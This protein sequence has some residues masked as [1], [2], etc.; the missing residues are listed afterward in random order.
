MSKTA[1]RFETNRNSGKSTL[2]GYFPIGY[3]TLEESIT[4]AIAMCKNGVDVLELGVP[5]SDPVMDGLVIQ[6]ATEQALANGFKLKQTFEAVARVTAEVDTPVL[7]MTYWNPVMQYGV[8]KFASELKTA[9]GAGLITPDLI[10]DE[11]SDWL[12]ISDRLDL[13]RVF[14]ATPTSSDSRMQRA[15]ELSRGFVYSVSTMG[16]TG[17]RD[18]VDD[19]AK[20]VVASV[21][22][23]ATK[24]NTAVGIGISTAEQVK[25]V[26]NY[27]DGAIVGSAFVRAFATGGLSTLI[28]KVKELNPNK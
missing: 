27:A 18:S 25:D 28:E 10:P 24:Q 26:N 7:V 19:L 13:D 15:C 23:T 9:G 14:L 6:E 8:E 20:K 16:I 11:A 22:K 17:T 4:A 21:R 5:Y 1:Q 3:P 2:V 12:E